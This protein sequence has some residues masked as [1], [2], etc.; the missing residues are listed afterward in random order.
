VSNLRP[1]VLSSLL[2]KSRDLR[3][4]VLRDTLP[5]WEWKAQRDG[6]GWTYEGR[7]DGREV[8]VCRFAQLWDYDDEAE[9]AWMVQEKNADVQSFFSWMSKEKT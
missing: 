4:E 3:I 2:R 7:R 5:G 8:R 9:G 6:F 1:S